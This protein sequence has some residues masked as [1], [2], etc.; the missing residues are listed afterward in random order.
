ME[1][2]D[3]IEQV[4]D[5][6]NRRIYRE[7][8]VFK[9]SSIVEN[10]RSHLKIGRWQAGYQGK[11]LVLTLVYPKDPPKEYYIQSINAVSLVLYEKGKA[12]T[13]MKMY[14]EAD[15]LMHQDERNDPF[16]PI[17]NQWRLKPVKPETDFAMFVVCSF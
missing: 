16:H 14:L 2:I 5:E 15:V 12:G 10:P 3:S 4:M 9:D 11:R 17:N 1:G 13:L 6:K 7:L 8:I